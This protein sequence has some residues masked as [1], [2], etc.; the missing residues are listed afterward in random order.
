LKIFQI[1]FET[2]QPCLFLKIFLCLGIIR[3]GMIDDDRGQ[4]QTKKKQK[5][6][7]QDTT[8]FVA[9]NKDPLLANF[10]APAFD[11]NDIEKKFQLFNGI[12]GR[13]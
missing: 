6:K 9:C 12:K 7:Q 1:K 5:R 4:G 11:L 3:L 13:V 2:F 8:I 10:K